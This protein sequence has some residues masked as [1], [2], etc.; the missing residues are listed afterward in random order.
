MR[1]TKNLC[2]PSNIIYFH[3]D[4][5]IEVMGIPSTTKLGGL[6][7]KE[8]LYLKWLC[9]KQLYIYLRQRCLLISSGRA[10]FADPWFI[11]TQ[12]HARR[13]KNF[14]SLVLFFISHQ[15]MNFIYHKLTATLLGCPA[16]SLC[17]FRK[18]IKSIKSWEKWGKRRKM[19]WHVSFIYQY[20]VWCN[21]NLE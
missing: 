8:K 13:S 5:W 6:D 14:S 12:K 10:N 17:S 2:F 4:V 11:V 20:N 18:P 3:Y 15:P 21:K 7:S 1:Y 16:H 9:K 19:I